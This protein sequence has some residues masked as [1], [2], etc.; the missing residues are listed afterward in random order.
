VSAEKVREANI[1]P[2]RSPGRLS[3]EHERMLR[4]DSAV[5]PQIIAARGYYTATKPSE[6]PEEFSARQRRRVG[7]VIPLYSPDGKTVSYQIRPNYPV[8]PK[9]KYENPRGGKIV[10]DVHPAM[11]DKIKDVREPVFFTEG[12]KTADAVTSQ[13]MCTVM[14][15]G[16]WNFAKPGTRCKK[17]LPCLK[18]VPLKGRVAYVGYD[19]DSCTNPQVQDALSRFVALLEERG[20]K[21]LV[22]YPPVV[23]DDPKTGFDDYLGTGGDFA[24]II[25]SA[26]PFEPVNIRRER[27]TK[28]ENL[29]REIKALWSMWKAMP[30]IKRSDCTDRGTMRE[31]IRIGEERGKTTP[32]GIKV[33]PSIRTLCEEVQI[34]RQGQANSIKRLE[35]KGYIRKAPEPRGKKEAQAYILLGHSAFSGHSREKEQSR[36]ESQTQEDKR[37]SFTYG[38]SFACV[39]QTRNVCEL[40]PELRESKVVH[41][42]ERAESP[43]GD[44]GRWRVV[45]S[46]VIPRLGKKRGEIIRY[47]VG[48]GKRKVTV[49]ELMDRFTATP[50]TDRPPAKRVWDFKRNCLAALQGFRKQKTKKWIKVDVDTWKEVE[51]DQVDLGPPIIEIDGDTV[52]LTPGW[53]KNLEIMREIGEEQEDARLQAEKIAREREGFH[54][55]DKAERTPRMPEREEVR[56]ILRAAAERDEDSR[57]EWQRRKVGV[58]AEVFVHDVLDQLGKIRMNLLNEVWK[59]EGG[60]PGDVALA[61]KSLRCGLLQLPEYDNEWFVYPPKPSQVARIK[62]PKRPRRSGTPRVHGGGQVVQLPRRG[63]VVEDWSTHPLDCECYACSCTETK[64]VRA[65]VGSGVGG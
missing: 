57:I 43:N 21:V 42:W 28:D 13:G 26:K 51:D 39:H 48:A 58:T 18:H 45:D 12:A 61:V 7:L 19:A 41:H 15:A 32:G 37:D 46:H 36:K 40:M 63:D 14:L 25:R 52:R 44:R 38:D 53:R 60:N 9:Q 33:S 2:A 8:S 4:E 50:K 10:A 6:V 23:N 56:R 11:R 47:L 30:T 17:L 31:L 62:P 35:E 3:P 27:L 34:G 54:N 16:V 59:D 55:P 64:Y 29:R 65:Y 24:E 22:V 1:T 5:S 20:A 49:E